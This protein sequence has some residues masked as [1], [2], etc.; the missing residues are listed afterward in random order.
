MATTALAFDADFASRRIDPDPARRP[1]APADVWNF[2][3]YASWRDD[4]WALVGTFADQAVQDA[5]VADPPEFVVSD[6][7]SWLEDRVRQVHGASIDVFDLMM[8]ALECRYRTLRAVHG[9]RTSNVGSFYRE[10]LRPL[11]PLRVQQRARDIFLSPAYPE[12]TEAHLDRAI[13][14]VSHETRSDR[15]YFD[16]NE[17]ELVRRNGHYMLYGSEY[18]LAIAS[19]I[20]GLRDY[21]PDMKRQGEAVV[22][23]CDV[24][25]SFLHPGAL[26]SFA[27][28][29]IEILFEELMGEA[30]GP[31]PTRGGA[32]SIRQ[33]LTPDH[34]VGHYTPV[35]GRDPFAG[36]P[37]P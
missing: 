33:T 14:A 4:A 8:D 20:E 23:L 30:D 5:F 36:A 13:V 22:F 9:T 18:L 10:G 15:V 31:S 27:G 2:H 25:L 35:V 32:F 17:T 28:R 3:D 29:A 19:H 6:D 1:A 26:R 12:L 21:R 37:W 34:I 7:M 11:D 24:P 16:C